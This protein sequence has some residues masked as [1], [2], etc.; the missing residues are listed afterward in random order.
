MNAQRIK[1]LGSEVVPTNH[2]PVALLH[3][4]ERPLSC[5]LFRTLIKS[6]DTN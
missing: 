3:A 6:D 2:P 1:I 4:G 5:P